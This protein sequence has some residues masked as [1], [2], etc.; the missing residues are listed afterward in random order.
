M[1]YTSYFLCLGPIFILGL[2]VQMVL[3]SRF[4]KYSR[5][6][7]SRNITGAQAARYILD[8]QGLRHVRIEH[9]GGFLSDHYDPRAQVLRL[10]PQVADTPSISAVGVAAHETGHA[11]QDAK[12]YPF[13]RF[14]SAIVPVVN[15]GSWVGPIV[16][17]IGLGLEWLT[18]SSGLGIYVAWLGV[19]LFS[20]VVLFAFVTLP[21]E[22]DASKRAKRLLYDSMIVDKNELKGV[23]SVLDAAAWTYVVAAIAALLQLLRW[24]WIVASLGRRR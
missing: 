7:T 9:V 8:S 3:K 5:V 2:V 20:A 10:S 16:I 14:R 13:L 19:F 23:D 1:Y 18:R 24:V 17:M 21:V 12:G 6:R 11:L 15:I 4:D 22:L